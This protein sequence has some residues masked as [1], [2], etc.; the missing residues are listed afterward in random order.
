MRATSPLSHS[1]MVR[2][3]ICCALGGRTA[4]ALLRR[5]STPHAPPEL[6]DAG[7]DADNEVVLVAPRRRLGLVLLPCGAEAGA[8]EPDPAEVGSFRGLGAVGAEEHGS[9]LLDTV[10]SFAAIGDNLRGT[11]M[12]TCK[13][14]CMRVQVA[15]LP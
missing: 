12:V 5:P 6:L 15:S 1:R 8:A 14:R 13:H 9:C 10:V 7:W 2:P 11:D 4:T 3:T